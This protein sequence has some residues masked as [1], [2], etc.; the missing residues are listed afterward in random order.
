M[1]RGELG[2]VRREEVGEVGEMKGVKVWE[3]RSNEGREIRGGKVGQ[4]IR[5]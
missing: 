4:V 3:F 2:K 1:R 5:N